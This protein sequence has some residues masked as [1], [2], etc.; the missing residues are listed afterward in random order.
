MTTKEKLMQRRLILVAVI[1]LSARVAVFG[2]RTTDPGSSCT[3]DASGKSACDD[4]DAVDITAYTG[5]AVDTFAAGNLKRYLNPEDSGE[6]RLRGIA[7][8]DFALRFGS[9]DNKHQNDLFPNLLWLYGETVH[10]VRSA[11]VDCD[12]NASI[13]VCKDAF[14]AANLAGNLVNPG[15]QTLYILRNA[16]SLEGFMGLRYEFMSLNQKSDIARANLYLKAQAGFLTVARNGNDVVD[17]HHV[18]L[19]VILTRGVFRDSYLE[20][21]RGRSDLFIDH[22]RSRTKIDGYVTWALVDEGD[23]PRWSGIRPFVQITMD[24]DLGPGADSIQSY[25][26]F[27]FDIRSLFKAD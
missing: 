11:D 24:A 26:G 2:Q 5:L 23:H 27:Q 20:A 13:P 12:A 9:L 21:G 15:Q 4:R 16:T 8:F 22:R 14:K 1:L 25:Y 7:G 18:G 6:V 3:S 10:G 17:L 19:G